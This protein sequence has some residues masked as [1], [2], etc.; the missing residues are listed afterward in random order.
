MSCGRQRLGY[1]SLTA[2]ICFNDLN[3]S[4]VPEFVYGSAWVVFLRVD[5]A[6]AETPNWVAATVVATTSKKRR[7]SRSISFDI[8]PA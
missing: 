5:R 1:I 4:L 8:W 3:G 6:K 7:R 2:S